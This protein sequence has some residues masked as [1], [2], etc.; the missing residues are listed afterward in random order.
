MKSILK[1]ILIFLLVITAGCATFKSPINGKYELE[2][3]KNDN[4]EKVTVLFVLSHYEQTIGIDAI[5]KLKRPQRNFNDIF[6]DALNEISNIEK[7]N[8]FT[9][10]PENVEKI[11]FTDKINRAKKENDYFMEIVFKKE[12]SFVKFFFS[13]I[14]SSMSATVIPMRYKYKYLVEVKVHNYKQELIKSYSR[15]AELHKWVQGFMIFLYP[16][17][18]EKRKREE[19]FVEYLHDIFKQ[20]ETEQILDYNKLDK[21][22]RTIYSSSEVCEVI[23]KYIPKDVISWNKQN[24]NGW[25]EKKDIA[26]IIHFPDDGLNE[27]MAKQAFKMDIETLDKKTEEEGILYRVDKEEKYPVLLISA[28]NETVLKSQLENNNHLKVLLTGMFYLQRE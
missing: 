7:P 24:L 26:I 17:H 25:V 14:S 11:E 10:N 19:L 2:T 23:E 4:A 18:H 9:I 20:I 1:I 22:T 16:F 6:A 15:D 27:K 5:P 13:I 21:V 8:S 3:K 28:R 12:K